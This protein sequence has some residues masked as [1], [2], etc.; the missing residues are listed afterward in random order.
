[1]IEILILLTVWLIACALCA[2]VG[3]FVGIKHK[4][5]SKP[6]KAP[7]PVSEQKIR[8]AEKIARELENFYSYDGTK[9]DGFNTKV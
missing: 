8:E 2:V 7:E 9:Q 6:Q 1:M 5:I 3:F 4:D